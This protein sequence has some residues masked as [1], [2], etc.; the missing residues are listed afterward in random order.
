M[1]MTANPDG[2]LNSGANPDGEQTGDAALD[3]LIQRENERE[4]A[5]E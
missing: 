3:F 2:E 1:T 5:A 4:Q